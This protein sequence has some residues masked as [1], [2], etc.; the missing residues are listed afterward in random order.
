M[1]FSV[2]VP[3]YNIEKYIRK[4]IDSVLAQSFTDYELIL[5]DDGSP[6]NCP[7]ICDEYAAKDNC[8]RVVHK[9]NGGVSKARNVGIDCAQGEY[10]SFIDGDDIVDADYIG[11]MYREMVSGGYDV[12]RLSWER[13]GVNFTYRVKFDQAGK[14]ALD[15]ETID[16]LF[17]CTNIW[18]LFRT[19]LHIRF[20]ENLKNGEDSLFVI[21]N[22][23][24]SNRK[25]LL[26]NKAYYHYTIVPKSASE[27][28]PTVRLVAHS[29]FLEHV[30]IPK[31]S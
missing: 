14:C 20:N 6:D 10:L 29:K 21:E 16:N 4:C 15:G 12:V 27:M 24:R 30:L 8:I 26:V 17:L 19:D 25:M 13:G 2:I 22:F 18:G 1:L 23:V 31:V 28:S 11:L 7:A 5:V 3:I 9:E